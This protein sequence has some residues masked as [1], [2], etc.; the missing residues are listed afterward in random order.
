MTAQLGDILIYQ[1]QRLSIC[2]APLG[3]YFRLGGASPGFEMSSTALIRG[4]VATWELT[5][6]RLY[7]V[8]L[9]GWLQDGSDARL[10]SVFPG[11]PERVFAHWYTGCVRIPQGKLLK[12]VHS[13]YASVYERDLLLDF[14][15]GLLVAT[16][17]QRNGVSDNPDAPRGYG[18]GAFTVFDRPPAPPVDEL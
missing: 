3:D 8:G 7:L 17:E 9:Q 4:Y 18:V 11:Y 12:Y 6:H 15:C 5:D 2:A 10:E 14:E 1:G 16:T 13:G